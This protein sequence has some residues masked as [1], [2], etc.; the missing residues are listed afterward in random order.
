MSSLRRTRSCGSQMNDCVGRAFWMAAPGR[1]EIRT[2]RLGTPGADEILVR[3]RYSAISRGTEALVF[4][5]RV[6]A[7][8]Y[9]RMRA[10]FQAGDFPGP[11]KYG[12]ANVGCVEEGP[13]ELRGRDVFVLYPH[14]T[15][16][17][18]PGSAA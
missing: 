15:R 13:G 4:Q 1:G 7:S 2:E 12:Y 5:G 14:Q 11:V 9:H 6:P 8:E 16:Y 17:L 10:P 3:A 18:V